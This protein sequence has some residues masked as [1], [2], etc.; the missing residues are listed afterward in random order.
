M[1]AK[2]LKLKLSVNVNKQNYDASNAN[3]KENILIEDYKC[4]KCNGECKCRPVISCKNESNQNNELYLFDVDSNTAN[5]NFNVNHIT[6]PPV[7]SINLI[8]GDMNLDICTCKL[9]GMDD[10]DPVPMYFES[11]N[12]VCVQC[13]K[14]M[15]K[16][17]ISFRRTRISKKT[18][19]ANDIIINRIDSHYLSLSQSP[20][21]NSFDPYT[22][23]SLESRSPLPEYSDQ[24]VGVDSS[25]VSGNEVSVISNESIEV[26]AKD[27]LPQNGVSPEQLKSRLQTLQSFTETDIPRVPV[28]RKNRFRQNDCCAL[29]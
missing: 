17:P 10:V 7:I 18:T 8:D 12:N 27:K 23:D 26:I 11:D 1:H 28:K 4:L 22:P 6:R 13:K 3:D 15:D 19:L 24:V 2:R 5:N 20:Y 21:T 29:S 9:I 14:L 16:Q 25:S